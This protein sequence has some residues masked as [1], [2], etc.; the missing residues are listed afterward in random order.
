MPEPLRFAARRDAAGL[1]APNRDAGRRAGRTA[2]A[3]GIAARSIR[4]A[5][6]PSDLSANVPYRLWIQLV[7]ATYARFQRRNGK[8][9]S[10]RY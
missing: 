2:R 7:S 10:N 6:R 8:C 1:A 4:G 5:A 3:C 9:L